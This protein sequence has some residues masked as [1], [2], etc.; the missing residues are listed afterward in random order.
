MLFSPKEKGQGLVE[1]AL[2][3]VLVAIVV[4]AALMILGPIIGNVF[5]DINSSLS[6]V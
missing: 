1:Y 4:I 6:G 3:L 5:S 2:I